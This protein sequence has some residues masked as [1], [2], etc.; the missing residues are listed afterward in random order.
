MRSLRFAPLILSLTALTLL[1]VSTPLPALAEEAL[2]SQ[3]QEEVLTS[4][5]LVLLHERWLAWEGARPAVKPAELRG[6]V[7]WIKLQVSGVRSQAADWL[8]DSGFSLLKDRDSQGSRRYTMA[9]GA[10]ATKWGSFHL[11]GRVGRPELSA[12]LRPRRY[13]PAF[14]LTV[15]WKQFIFELE[16][17]NDKDFGYTVLSGFRWADPR[18]RVQYGLALPVSVDQGPSIAGILQVLIRLDDVD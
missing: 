16:A 17:L 12:G 18:G 10:I 11:R 9:A 7:D 4:T 8:D 3:E 5:Q 1:P 15:P 13:A 2:I 14:G 6:P